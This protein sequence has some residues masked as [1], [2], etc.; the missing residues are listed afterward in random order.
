MQWLGCPD[1]S[2]K[3]F[4]GFRHQN[5]KKD[6]TFEYIYYR[7]KASVTF[8]ILLS[9]FF[10]QSPLKAV[11]VIP[12][13]VNIAKTACVS[14][15]LVSFFSHF[16]LNWYELFCTLYKKP[17][18]ILH[19][20]VCEHFSHFLP[21]LISQ[22]PNWFDEQVINFVYFSI[23]GFSTKYSSKTFWRK[24]S[25]GRK[26]FKIS[27]ERFFLRVIARSKLNFISWNATYRQ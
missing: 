21:F 1:F 20:W 12:S 4:S 19:H 14:K 15:S 17:V 26:I 6:V 5:F 27:S 11:M 8:N 25:F 22:Q 23:F 16:F 3:S 7:S 18:T 13:A 9:L 24:L 2:A 10:T